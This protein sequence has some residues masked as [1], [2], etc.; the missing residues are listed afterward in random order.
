MVLDKLFGWVRRKEEDPP[1]QLGRYSDNNK[2]VQ[3]VARWTDADNLFKEK[4]YLKSIEAFFDYLCDDEQANVAVMREDGVLKFLI[5]QGS[6]KAQGQV[7]D[8]SVK[9]EIA[10]AGLKTSSV[11]VMR[12]LLEMN[13]NLFYTRYAIRENRVFIRFDTPLSSASPNKMYYGLKELATK[14]DKQDDLLVAEFNALEHIDREHVI[15]LPEEEKAI[16]HAYLQSWITETL[17]FIDTLDHEKFSGGIS[18]LLLSLVF[19][20][21]YLI[22]PEGRMLNE[23]EKIATTYYSNKDDKSSAERNPQMIEGFRKLLKKPKEEI[24][25]HLFRSKYTFAIVVPHNLKTVKETIETSLEN[26]MWYR[27][28]NYPDIANKVM[29]YGF[30][31]NQYSYSLPKPLS[32]LFRLF[33]QVNYSRYFKDLG[34]K[35]SYFDEERNVFNQDEIEDHIESVVDYWKNKYS[36]L[37]FKTKKLKYDSLLSFNHSF[38]QEIAS[39]NFD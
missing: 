39:L 13:F 8:A 30:A 6:V 16:K 37:S 3:K 36:S 21:D 28:N 32:D 29:E 4:E 24:F 25:D 34:F 26:M 27:D 20:I 18:Y 17:D 31:Y 23:L 11:P 19:R 35:T 5:Y 14:A 10:I 1:I 38:L 12:K 7:N 22:T 9:A 33:M 2:S 15:N